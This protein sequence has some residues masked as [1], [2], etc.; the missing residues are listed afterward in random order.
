[1]EEAGITT[2]IIGSALDIVEHC[3]APRFVF[4]DLPLGNPL[5]KPLDRAMQ[6][7]SILTALSLA[8]EANQAGSI[9]LTGFRFSE[10]ED[11]KANYA[12]VDES[13]REELLR[14]GEENRKRRA[15]NNSA[16]VN[17]K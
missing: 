4:N 16:G 17:R 3:G 8:T 6:R 14:L 2:V 9:I 13:N 1:L 15:M 12:R 10:S 11:W 5:G 7:S